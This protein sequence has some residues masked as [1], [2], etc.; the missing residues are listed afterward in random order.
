[1]D[2]KHDSAQTLGC[3]A[4][5]L[6]GDGCDPRILVHDKVDVGYLADLGFDVRCTADEPVKWGVYGRHVVIVRA[7]D[8]VDGEEWS[9]LTK[10]LAHPD[11]GARTCRIVTVPGGPTIWAAANFG[12]WD[13]DKFRELIDADEEARGGRRYAIDD[14]YTIATAYETSRMVDGFPTIRCH[15]GVTLRYDGSAWI[16]M[17]ADELTADVG[18]LVER[19]VGDLNADP[20][21]KTLARTSTRLISEV[22]A[23]AK[24]WALLPDAVEPPCWLTDGP[25]P[26]PAEDVLACRNGLL[27]LPSVTFHEPHPLY[28]N[29]FALDYDFNEAAPPPARWLKLLHE[30]WPDDP[31]SVELLQEWAGYLLTADTRQQKMLA[32]IGEKRSGKGTIARILGA[33]IGA[34]NVAAPTLSALATNFGCAPLIGKSLAVVGDARFSGRSDYVVI[35]E[36]LLSISGEDHI[37]IDRKYGEA[38]TG[39]LPTRFMLLTNQLPKLTDA[40]GALVSRMLVLKFT[41]TFLG[42]EDMHLFDRILPELPGVLLWAI[43][44][45]RRLHERGYFVQAASGQDEIDQML[46]LSSPVTQFVRERCDVGEEKYVVT[47]DLFAAWQAWCAE[48]G[49]DKPG[50][51]STF[52]SNLRAAFPVVRTSNPTV[53]DG[54]KNVRLYLGIAIKK[55]F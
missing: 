38:W 46:E 4:D 47:S 51:A 5:D 18:G 17:S 10:R 45:W 37:T 20:D 26:F 30:I 1:V 2:K 40:S 42:R 12:E 6:N 22:A 23:A 32:M 55:D 16:P 21:R 14:P 50:K 49:H 44:G 48:N 9:K 8:D 36:R 24:R 53:R 31:E 34:R 15:R 19:Y 25:T 13:A 33:M 43:E 39:K 3:Q 11:Q 35:V 27:H 52:G 7:Q 41:R 29:T 54:R 28:F